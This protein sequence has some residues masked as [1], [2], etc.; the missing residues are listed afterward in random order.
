MIDGRTL[1]ASLDFSQGLRN[2]LGLQ[3]MQAEQQRQQSLQSALGE[4]FGY[5]QPT[6]QIS[7]NQG[8]M[9]PVSG[10][11]M[12]PQ[13]GGINMDALRKVYALDPEAGAR[14]MQLVEAQDTARMAQIQ[15]A[16]ETRARLGMSIA[17]RP[18]GEQR[19]QYIDTLMRESLAAGDQETAAGLMELQNMDEATQNIYIRDQVAQAQPF[20]DVAGSY[21]AQFEAPEYTAVATDESGRR[22]GVNKATG[23]QELIPGAEGVP[24]RS[25]APT[26]EIKQFPAPPTGYY[27][28]N[29]EQPGEGLEPIPGGPAFKATEGQQMTA[30][31]SQRMEA[32][33]R[34]MATVV[35][36]GYNPASVI[37]HGRA[38]L[39][40]PVTSE[41]HKLF[42]QA[43]EDWVRAKLRKESGAV[44]GPEE[45]QQEIETYFPMP[46]DPPRVVEQKA[47]AR[48]TAMEAMRRSAGPAASGPA[49][50]ERQSDIPPPPPGAI[51]I[52][53]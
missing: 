1:T 4:L 34:R 38:W 32:A 18:Y 21:L 17:A 43:Q 24:F 11:P 39:G 25:N 22:W 2:Y 9:T 46:Y 49:Q 12:P 37:E 10:A 31:Y 14:V 35:D 6:G 29:P 33:E 42:R 27:Y 5:S 50:N 44:I 40:N 51:I 13:A 15:K 36:E 45:M 28:R 53:R 48:R 52:S 8:A 7:G 19:R 41:K 16:A 23:R 3:N 26:V 47:Q 20:A 30:G